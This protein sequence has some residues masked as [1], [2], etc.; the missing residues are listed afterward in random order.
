MDGVWTIKRLEAF[1]HHEIWTIKRCLTISGRPFQSTCRWVMQH[2]PAI[3]QLTLPPFTTIKHK[4]ELV[5]AS[6][7]SKIV[8]VAHSE[9]SQNKTE[10]GTESHTY[11]CHKGAEN[12]TYCTK[13]PPH[14]HLSKHPPTTHPPC[15]YTPHIPAAPHTTPLTPTPPPI[16]DLWERF[17]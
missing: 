7:L 3:L 16:Q 6:C 9:E 12:Q 13:C 17:R 14:N 8:M 2:L 11:G 1:K 4:M 5:A 10:G 15:T